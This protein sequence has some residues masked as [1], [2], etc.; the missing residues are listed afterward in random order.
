LFL[1]TFPEKINQVQPVFIWMDADG[2]MRRK[3]RS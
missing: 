2:N 3:I 1:S